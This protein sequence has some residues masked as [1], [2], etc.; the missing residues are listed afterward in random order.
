MDLVHTTA[1][2]AAPRL[3]GC[4]ISRTVAGQELR[5]T[6]VE[7]EAYHQDDPASH[8]YRGRTRRN[9]SMFGPGGHA[10][11]YFTYGMH[12]CFNI[13]TGRSGY[14]G[15]VLIRAVA[16]SRGIKVIQKNRGRNSTPAD[17]IDSG[18]TNGP[19][20]FT[21]A[22]AIDTKL[23]GH[24]LTQPPLQLHP[25]PPVSTQDITRTTRIGIR[26]NQNAKLRF[27]ITG[28]PYVSRP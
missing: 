19:A 24:D 23:D 5:G 21:Q 3:L 9:R 16:P 25:A 27:Y 4:T 10:Y 18:L 14:G 6:I 11:V 13:V 15:A 22:F 12:Y 7:T 26:A 20:K 28:N 8:T 17:R 2:A 1:E